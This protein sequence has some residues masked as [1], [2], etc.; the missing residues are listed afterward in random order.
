MCVGSDGW[1]SCCISGAGTGVG[2]LGGAC[3]G[4]GGGGIEKSIGFCLI[5]LM[6]LRPNLMMISWP[7]VSSWSL[8]SDGSGAVWRSVGV[9]GRFTRYG[10]WAGFA[11]YE[12]IHPFRTARVPGWRFWRKRLFA[13]ICVSASRT[14]SS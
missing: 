2:G 9:M 7:S 13:R 12:T 6:R 10:R 1:T 14:A 4:G 8:Y 11:M 5:G 3:A